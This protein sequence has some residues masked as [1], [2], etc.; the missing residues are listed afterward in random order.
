MVARSD[1]TVRKLPILLAGNTYPEL[2]KA[3]STIRPEAQFVGNGYWW[4]QF[5][6]TQ[7]MDGDTTITE[8]AWVAV[9]NS[10]NNDLYFNITDTL[11][12]KR[13]PLVSPF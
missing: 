11:A 10:T 6:W 3:G 4:V 7:R 8:V 5:V 12:C 9:Q 1:R 13:L 2:L